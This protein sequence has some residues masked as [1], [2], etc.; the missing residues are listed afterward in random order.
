M[1]PRSTIVWAVVLAGC[2]VLLAPRPARAQ[3]VQWRTDYNAALKEAKEKGIP[4]ILDFFTVPC[5]WCD[6]LDSTTY[7]DPAVVKTISEHFIAVKIQADREPRLTQI[8]QIS[9]YPTVV[10]ADPARKI[11]GT[12]EGY[13]EPARFHENLQRALAR[14]AN[15][16]W[17]VRDYQEAVKAY[18]TPDYAK[19]VTLLKGVLEDGKTRPVQEKARQLLTEIEK[20]AAG[21]LARARQLNDKGQATEA[22]SA[23]T[24]LVRLYP[25]TPEAA[26]AGQLLTQ[27][28]KLPEVRE[29]QRNQRAR[30]L[31]A[32]AK[33]DYRTKQYVCCLDRCEILAAAFGDLPEGAEAVQ[34]A[35]EIKGNPEWMQNACDSLTERLSSM[36]LALAETWLH[37]GQPQ[38][39]AVC[40]ERVI[41]TFPNSRQ[42]EV[43]Q[44]RLSQIQGQ[45]NRAVEFQKQ[46]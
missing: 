44:I 43:A 27:L 34:L 20:Q 35:A 16:E 39:A 26:E 22:V 14:V 9:S 37:K 4:L 1:F 2:A 30:E 15:P 5:I 19:A 42:A 28:V 46:Q 23:L 8:L 31:L 36:Y 29:K 24:E 17:M 18:S 21:K 6:R 10:L 45:P 12:I 33:E 32:Q 38:Q 7:K 40:L 41:R 25:G 13:Q 11:L 3:A